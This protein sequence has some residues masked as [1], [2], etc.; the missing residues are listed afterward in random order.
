MKFLTKIQS[1]SDI[2][3]NSSSE[4][5]LMHEKDAL[6]YEGLENTDNCIYIEKVTKEWLLNNYWNC[7]MICDYLDIEDRPDSWCSRED[8]EVFI[9]FYIEPLMD[10]LKDI[11]FVNIEDHFPD[12]CE[13]LD[14]AR[15]DA[16]SWES[17]H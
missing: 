7:D 11:Y 14:S 6:Y 16:L 10:K 17:R 5:F 8:W 4:T 15:S 12:C 3:T 13:V 1:I 2:I 9:E